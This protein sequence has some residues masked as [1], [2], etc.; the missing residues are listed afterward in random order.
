[1]NATTNARKRWVVVASLL[2]L[3]AGV[4][5]FSWARPKM[6]PQQLPPAPQ[7]PPGSPPIC[8]TIRFLVQSAH[9]AGTGTET[10]VRLKEDIEA[11]Q[12]GPSTPTNRLALFSRLQVPEP[13]APELAGDLIQSRNGRIGLVF[14]AAM[15][16][17][18]LW[19]LVAR[20]PKR[21]PMRARPNSQHTKS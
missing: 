10:L 7:C 15:F 13:H 5:T 16:G 17:G 4:A 14:M 2:T 12:L 11:A 1:M 3:V 6:E 18:A 20:K 19:Q 21:K 9:E 8:E